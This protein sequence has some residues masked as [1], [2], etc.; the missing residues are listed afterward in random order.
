MMTRLPPSSRT[1]RSLV[2]AAGLA[3][4]A[5]VPGHAAAVFAS[6]QVV[7]ELLTADASADATVPAARLRLVQ[8]PN[9]PMATSPRCD[10]L[11]NF[12]D[13]RS[14]GR[15]HA[16][17]DI[18]ATSGQEIYAM[19]DGTLTLQ[20]IDGSG[21]H[22]SQLSGNLWKLVAKTGGTY[23]V[24]AHLSAFAPGLAQGSL[25]FKGQVIGYVGD[26]GDAGPGNYHLH[27]EWHPNG[28]AAVN[29]VPL[30]T[31]PTACKVWG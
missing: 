12:G 3:L 29:A 23:W 5:A 15:T 22:N 10:I 20:V 7:A 18:L 2:L 6:P 25:V 28:G 8:P 30:M 27:F 14:G 17:T 13:P 4:A 9:F 21:L 1:L 16:G 26:T 31:V 11:D 24:Y 19:A